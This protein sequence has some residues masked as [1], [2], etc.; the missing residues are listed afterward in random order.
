MLTPLGTPLQLISKLSEGP[1]GL[2]AFC[3]CSGRDEDAE[4]FESRHSESRQSESRQS[5]SRQ[6]ESRQI[7]PRQS[8]PRQSEPRQIEFVLA[9]ARAPCAPVHILSILDPVWD[10]DDRVRVEM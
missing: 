9:I 7:E 10:G 4:E 3:V 2:G 5:E 1:A 6:T 8:E